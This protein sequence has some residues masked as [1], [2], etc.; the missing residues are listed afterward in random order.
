MINENE[1]RPIKQFCLG[2]GGIASLKREKFLEHHEW[3]LKDYPK[4]P[5]KVILAL[6][7][8]DY[9]DLG[10]YCIENKISINLFCKDAVLKELKKAKNKTHKIENYQLGGL[11]D[12]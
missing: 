8:T 10:L 4:D 11:F 9:I 2:R 6:H 5:T 7:L 12:V 1:P 3:K